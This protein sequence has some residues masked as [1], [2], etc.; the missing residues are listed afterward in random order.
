VKTAH[1]QLPSAFNL[2]AED[3]RNNEIVAC[4]GTRSGQFLSFSV[5]DLRDLPV[6]TFAEAL[7]LEWLDTDLEITLWGIWEAKARP[8]HRWLDEPTGIALKDE[9]C[10]Q[11]INK[12]ISSCL[13]MTSPMDGLAKVLSLQECLSHQM[14]HAVRCADFLLQRAATQDP[15]ALLPAAEDWV[16]KAIE[17]S[18]AGKKDQSLD[19]IFDNIDEMLLRSRFEACDSVLAK[20]PLNQLSNAQLITVLTATLAAKE[21]LR[22]REHFFEQ[23]RSILIERDSE[24]ELLLRG[25]R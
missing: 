11:Q 1:R 2:D 25:L 15:Q 6:S 23:V 17:L 10:F 13:Q 18:S 24:V 19:V 3:N 8:A 5:E 9:D 21:R 12:S 22:N 4:L 7:V 20:L 14:D 16:S